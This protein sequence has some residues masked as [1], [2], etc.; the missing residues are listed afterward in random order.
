MKQTRGSSLR[1]HSLV[2]FM[3]VACALAGCPSSPIERVMDAGVLSE[4]MTSFEA[5]MTVAM[6]R[7]MAQA[8]DLV[9]VEDQG[10]LGRCEREGATSQEQPKVVTDEVAASLCTRDIDWFGVELA[11]GCR[12]TIDVVPSSSLMT[13][14]L[15]I[16]RAAGQLISQEARS[17]SSLDP[18]VVTL[19]SMTP[20]VIRV[21][22][23]ADDDAAGDYTV[24]VKVQCPQAALSC[25]LGDD[26]FEDNNDHSRGDNPAKIA[27]GDVF[28]ASMCAAGADPYARYDYY[29][30]EDERRWRGCILGTKL[31]WPVTPRP[32]ETRTNN[33]SWYRTYESLGLEH[34]LGDSRAGGGPWQ[35]VLRATWRL[36]EVDPARAA[37]FETPLLLIPELDLVSYRDPNLDFEP[38]ATRWS[39]QRAS[40]WL[41]PVNYHVRVSNEAYAQDGSATIDAY[42][43]DVRAL[44]DFSCQPRPQDAFFGIP[45]GDDWFD[46]YRGLRGGFAPDLALE[47][48]GRLGGLAR[49]IA[50]P[51][52]P[53]NGY[54]N[55]DDRFTP[56][57]KDIDLINMT[58]FGKGYVQ[59]RLVNNRACVATV[60]VEW[61]SPHPPLMAWSSGL[62]GADERVWTYDERV[63]KINDADNP[64]FAH[65][66]PASAFSSAGWLEDAPPGFKMTTGPG[67]AELSATPSL[68]TGPNQDGVVQLALAHAPEN[69]PQGTPWSVEYRCG[70]NP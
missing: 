56:Y 33:R 21:S 31:T 19:A 44:C 37:G 50:C 68:F 15:G 30:L 49:G 20:E 9:I 60:R 43:L 38:A 12:A 54:I 47:Q 23:T 22:V 16:W 65:A 14:S 2:T 13:Y 3:L 58:A 42:T 24:K 53:Y 51:S 39:Y 25:Q 46:A 26:L 45:A 27:I 66:S 57:P 32:D 4:E 62:I 29:T 35:E 10:E 11:P 69:G 67:W 59:G 61:S 1:L 28:M 36:G 6:P 8:F 63:S 18:S 7:D 34:A 48:G 41:Y 55:V 64:F 5:E 40:A 70:S 17:S 52:S